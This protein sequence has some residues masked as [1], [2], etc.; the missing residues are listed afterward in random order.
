MGRTHRR[1]IYTEPE[2][3]ARIRERAEKMGISVNEWYHRIAEHYLAE[4]RI[5]LTY[6]ETKRVTL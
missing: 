3:D 2:L 1:L 6:T 5:D 4:K